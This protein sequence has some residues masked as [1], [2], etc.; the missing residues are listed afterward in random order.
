MVDGVHAGNGR[1]AA[2]GSERHALLADTTVQAMVSRLAGTGRA[3]PTWSIGK[4]RTASVL[5]FDAMLRRL[6][7]AGLLL[8]PGDREGVV[9]YAGR[10][11]D[12]VGRRYTILAPDRARLA[13]QEAGLTRAL[14][15][16]EAP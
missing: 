8:R 1:A 7:D 3:A 15:H 14:G 11:P 9:L 5:S 12:G 13:E 4:T 16:E 6:D 10:P 2:A